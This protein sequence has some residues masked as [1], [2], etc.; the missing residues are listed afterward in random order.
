MLILKERFLQYYLVDLVTIHNLVYM[1]IQSMYAFALA[2]T[3][4]IHWLP[5]PIPLLPL[6]SSLWW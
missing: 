2:G 6:E 5:E 1:R 4:R 3:G